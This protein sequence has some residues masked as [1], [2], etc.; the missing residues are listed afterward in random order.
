MKN[1]PLIS[2][3]TVVYNGEQYL[4]QTI[5][6]VI[7]QTYK[8][9][10]YIIIDGGSTDNT[11]EIIKTNKN[12]IDHWV[13]EPD[14]G[15]YDAMNKGIKLAKGELIGI[16]N[17][18]DWYEKN[19]I[20]IV[21]NTYLANPHKHIFHA[22]RYDIL[23]NGKRREYKY[24]QSKFKFKYYNMTFSHPSVFVTKDEYNKHLYNT[25]IKSMSDYQFLMEAFLEDPNKFHHIDKPLVNFRLG[26]ISGQLSFW[27]NI[28]EAY[29]VR[30]NAGMS[31][32]E[33]IFAAVFKT[34]LRPLVLLKGLAK[35]R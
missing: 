31:F 3:V 27:E 12:S 34:V 11:V 20:E 30:K 29:L 26:G 23:P 8:N 2:I 19:T 22:N 17:S 10:E 25:E 4:Q 14:K 5:D 32:G 33:R 18:D 1:A 15:L 35:R 9:I 28:K 6:S 7:G 13:S 24:H 16:I 21:V